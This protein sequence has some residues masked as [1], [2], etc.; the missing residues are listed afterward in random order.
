MLIGDVGLDAVGHL[1]HQGV[2]EGTL[3]GGLA[4]VRSAACAVSALQLLQGV[5]LGHVLGELVVDGRDLLVLDL[6]DLHMEHDGLA[7]QLRG[8]SPRGR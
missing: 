1:L 8:D 2:L 4:V 5:E 3:G 7:G 6:V